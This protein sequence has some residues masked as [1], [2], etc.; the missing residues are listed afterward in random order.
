M[1]NKNQNRTLFELPSVSFSIFS[2][3]AKSFNHLVLPCPADTY[4]E[5]IDVADAV[6]CGRAR[7]SPRVFGPCRLSQLMVHCCLTVSSV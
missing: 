3:K 5:F 4:S 1:Q 6:V 7:L 2:G